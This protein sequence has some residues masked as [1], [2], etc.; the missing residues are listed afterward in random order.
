MA[1][2]RRTL[3]GWHL[4]PTQNR[5]IPT[6]SQILSLAGLHVEGAPLVGARVRAIAR[7]AR[8]GPRTRAEIRLATFPVLSRSAVDAAFRALEPT[9]REVDNRARSRVRMLREDVVPG[10]SP[11]RDHGIGLLWCLPLTRATDAGSAST[12]DPTER[13]GLVKGRPEDWTSA[14]ETAGDRTPRL[15]AAAGA[16]DHAFEGAASARAGGLRLAPGTPL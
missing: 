6:D 14:P 12:A 8:T 15:T 7:S 1:N 3:R 5:C 2:R 9:P 11:R 10:L 13:S 16:T 4:P